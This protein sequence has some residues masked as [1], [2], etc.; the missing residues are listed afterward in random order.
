MSQN[1]ERARVIVIELE[2]E[3]RIFL[4]NLLDAGGFEPIVFEDNLEDL[5]DFKKADPALII[6]D[7]MIPKAGSVRIYRNLKKDQHLKNI[8]VIMLSTIDQKTFFQYLKVQDSR[9][10]KGVPEPNGYLKKPPEAE[11]LLGFVR[12]LTT[13][14]T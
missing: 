4:S 12:M 9:F 10:G 11:Q 13:K 3:M 5:N 2:P 6:L 1:L 14:A 7:A 8:P